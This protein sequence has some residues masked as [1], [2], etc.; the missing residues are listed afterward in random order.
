M[1]VGDD[2]EC[3]KALTDQDMKDGCVYEQHKHL[4]TL[5]LASTRSFDRFSAFFFDFFEIL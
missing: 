1:S 3:L 2:I 5:R 4:Y